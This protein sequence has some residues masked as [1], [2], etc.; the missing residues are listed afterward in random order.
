LINNRIVDIPAYQVRTGEVISV[1]EK[2]KNL[3][4]IHA[5]L[6]EAGRGTEFPWLRLD[7]AHL[8]GE[9]LEKPKRLDIPLMVQEQLVVEYYSR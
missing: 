6:R 5:S 8:Q 7:K 4:I 3:D 9:L 2:S 1:R